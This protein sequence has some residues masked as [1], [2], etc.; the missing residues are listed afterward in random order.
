MSIT[1]SKWKL[2]ETVIGY[3]WW[4]NLK[5]MLV[6]VTTITNYSIDVNE[7]FKLT[8]NTKIDEA[9]KVTRLYDTVI[10]VRINHHKF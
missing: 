1:K 9:S 5:K 3:K 4:D 10:G 2:I 6:G 7:V 8:I